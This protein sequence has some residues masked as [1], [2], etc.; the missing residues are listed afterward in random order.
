MS[1]NYKPTKFTCYL[2]YLSMAA[3]A[4]LPPLLFLPFREMFGISYTLLG[5]LVLINFFTQLAV[6]LSFTFF[7]HRLNIHKAIRVMPMLLAL[8]FVVYGLIPTLFPANAYLGLCIGTVLFSAAAGLCEVLLSP[9]VAALPSDNPDREMS[10]LHS[11]YAYGL[12]FVIIFSTVFLQLFGAKNWLWLVLLFSA[13]PVVVAILFATVPL[14]DM[15]VSRA[16]NSARL[17]KQG[18]LLA[19]CALCIFLGSAAENTMTNWVSSYMEKALGF[20]KVWGDLLGMAGF[21]ILLGLARTW[22][23]RRGKNILN[24]LLVG[25]IGATVCYVIAGTVSN[26][27]IASLACILTGWFT[28]ML[29]PGTLILMEERIPHAGV[30]A[31]ALMAACGDLGAS[32]APQLM[33]VLVDTVAAS[34]WASAFV[35]PE[36][37]GMKVAALVTT[38]FPLLGAMLLLGMKKRKIR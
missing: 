23:A 27:I 3:V 7:A 31:Y 22:Y 6:D 35:S 4:G 16:D 30:T 37:I 28:S 5:T 29:W 18:R 15:T 20:S 12:L 21:A 36:Q 24:T 11:L 17:G 33:G 10:K 9:L 2:S 25:M 1:V 14:P 8:G 19:L 13:V 38:I 32:L 34:N 26:A